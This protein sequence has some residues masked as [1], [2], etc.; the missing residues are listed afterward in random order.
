MIKLLTR[1]LAAL[2]CMIIFD[3]PEAD[4]T[5]RCLFFQGEELCKFYSRYGICKF[6]ANCKF[7]HPMATPMGVYAYGFSASASPASASTNVP[8]A[9]RLL[10][11]PSGSGYTS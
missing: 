11:S 6:G 5:I 8:M 1:P 4:N 7:D 10:G 9:R 3:Y 2:P